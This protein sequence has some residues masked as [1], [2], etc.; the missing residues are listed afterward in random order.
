VLPPSFAL[1]VAAA[2]YASMPSYEQSGFRITLGGWSEVPL[3]LGEINE[4]E[5]DY[6]IDADLV[7]PSSLTARTRVRRFTDLQ[8]R[9]SRLQPDNDAALGAW[10]TE[11]GPLGWFRGTPERPDFHFAGPSGNASKILWAERVRVLQTD[12]GWATG[13]TRLEWRCAVWVM[14]DLLR[15]RRWALESVIPDE[16]SSP[17]W[18][19]PRPDSP[20]I[21]IHPALEAMNTGLE[22]FSPRGEAYRP[23]DGEAPGYRTFRVTDASTWELAMAAFW[24]DMFRGEAYSECQNATCRYVFQ[25]QIGRALHAQHRTAGVKYCSAECA[26]AQ[27]Q[28]AY[29]DR[30]RALKRD[31]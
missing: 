11:H 16:W 15:A 18:L 26:R 24:N 25:H 21:G 30:Q 2:Y 6:V 5:I 9:L 28:R 10:V 23:D 17:A 14:Q 1:A 3:P 27:A 20:W 22:A 7:F 29:R 8:F 19:W 4:P 12:A 13:D 31:A